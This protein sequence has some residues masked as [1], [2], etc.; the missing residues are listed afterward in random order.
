MPLAFDTL[1]HGHEN[2]GRVEK[3]LR[4]FARPANAVLAVR[5]EN[6]TVAIG[7]CRFAAADFRRVV[8]YLWRGGLPS[9]ES[10]GRPDYVQ[11]LA[12]AAGRSDHG[13]FAGLMLAGDRV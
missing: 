6:R 3:R 4:R 13:L 7:S 1:G 8:A 9:R 12:A 2:R 5:S 10:G 11:R